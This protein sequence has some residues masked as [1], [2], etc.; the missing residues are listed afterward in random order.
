MFCGLLACTD[1]VDN[2]EAAQTYLQGA[3]DILTVSDGA[4]RFLCR[5]GRHLLHAVSGESRCSAL[6]G[7]HES[8][9]PQWMKVVL[10][11]LNSLTSFRIWYDP[12]WFAADIDLSSRSV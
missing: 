8:K 11:T 3:V 9:E 12:E 10:K 5:V 2:V 4:E 1:S 7:S 6:E